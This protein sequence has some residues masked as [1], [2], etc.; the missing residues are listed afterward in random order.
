MTQIQIRRG[1]ASAWTAANPIL[2]QGEIA[3]E[4]DTKKIKVGDG[5]TAWNS[6]GYW[7]IA[8]ADIIDRKSVV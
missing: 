2:A 4:L 1:N 8:W 5:S 3:V 6:L 7:P